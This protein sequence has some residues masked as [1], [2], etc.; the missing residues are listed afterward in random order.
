M[1][2]SLRRS[3]L[4]FALLGLASLAVPSAAFSQEAKPETPLVRQLGKMDFA[5]LGAGEFSTSSNGTNYLS[6]TV[7]LKPSSTL[8]YRI[9]LHYQKSPWF[10]LQFNYGYARYSQNFTLGASTTTSTPAEF[11]G[12]QTNAKEFTGSYVVHTP[13]KYFGVIPFAEVG[14]GT[15]KFAPTAAGGE[16][17]KQQYRALYTGGIGA[18]TYLLGDHF[19]ARAE[20]REMFYNAPDYLTNYVTIHQR[21][22][23]TQPAVGV[24]LRF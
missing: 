21:A 10:G 14:A 5:V 12:I 18:E 9:T 3:S 24:F 23:T 22:M 8:G 16:G 20:L 11:F 17:F 6:Q 7:N 13:H 15:L 19:G 2:I 1:V 4:P